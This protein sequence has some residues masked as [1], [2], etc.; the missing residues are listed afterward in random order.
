MKSSSITG[1]AYA[2]IPQDT[3]NQATYATVAPLMNDFTVASNNFYLFEGECPSAEILQVYNDSAKLLN[4]YSS[5]LI[6]KILNFD[7]KYSYD[8]VS[9]TRKLQKFPVDA[10][11][12]T[13]AIDGV[14][15][16]CCIELAPVAISSPFKCL[17]FT[18]AIG[19]WDDADQSILVSSTT[20]VKGESITIKDI[21]IT[22]RDAMLTELT[23]AI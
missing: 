15:G 5:R 10:K 13:S 22:L 2:F 18:N 9:R 19:G 17:I 8:Q 4:D 16:W 12:M 3:T 20:C 6:T 11:T 14:A 21:N 7:I 1:L 23:P